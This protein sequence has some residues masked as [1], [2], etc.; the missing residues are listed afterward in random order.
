MMY[1]KILE[2]FESNE[3][4]QINTEK[5]NDKHYITYIQCQ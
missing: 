2:I 3:K 4:E 1:Y 5:R